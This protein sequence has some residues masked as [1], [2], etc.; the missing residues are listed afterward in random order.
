MEINFFHFLR[1][2]STPVE[3]VSHLTR[4]YWKRGNEYFYVFLCIVLFRV[5]FCKW[6]LLLKLGG[7]QFFKD[8]PYSCQW[9]PFFSI[10]KR[11]FKVEATFPYGGNLFFNILHLPSGNSTFLSVLFHWVETIIGIRRKQF[12]EKELILLVDNCFSG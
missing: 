6:K 5:F 3:A 7:S 10:F 4:T 9:T 8:D 2:Q 11:F 1:Q 12:W